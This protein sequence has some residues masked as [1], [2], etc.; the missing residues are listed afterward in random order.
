MGQ[1]ACLRKL[2]SAAVAIAACGA[3]TGAQATPLVSAFEQGKV[4]IDVRARYEGVSDGNCT[5]CAGRDAHARTLRARL[6]FATADWNGFSALFEFDRI[7]TL[8]PQDYNSKTNGR[9]SFPV[10]ADPVMTALDRLQL[11]YISPYDTAIVAG[12]QRIVLGNERF[13]G[14]VGFRQHEQTFDGVTLVNTSLPDTELTYAWI[15]GVNR[16]FG[17]GSHGGPATGRFTGSSHLLNAVYAGIAHLKLEG[18]AYLLDLKQAPA[19]STATYGIRAEFDY[20]LGEGVSSELNGAFAHQT[21]Y[22]RNPSKVSLDYWTLEGAFAYAGFSIGAGYEA[23]EGNGTAGFATPLATLHAFDGWADLFLTTPE[24]GIDDLYVKASYVLKNVLGIATLSPQAIYHSFSTGR[25]D[26]G[27]GHEWD[28]ALNA[29]FDAH[30]SIA[31]SYAAYD[32]AGIGAGGFR[33][34]TIAWFTTVYRF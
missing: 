13:V 32:G 15:G 31:A 29:A 11:T 21:D 8:G 9:T 14:N 28:I 5:A 33:N 27:I 7:W 2:S 26:T 18:Y 4:L 16:V 6:G 25:T 19:A 24:N 3:G 30:F 10:V 17:P 34:K 12:R 20:P 1:K 22:A 23:L